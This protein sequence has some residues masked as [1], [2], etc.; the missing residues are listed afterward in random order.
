MPCHDPDFDETVVDFSDVE[1]VTIT[2]IDEH[3]KTHTVVLSPAMVEQTQDQMRLWKKHNNI[4]S[5]RTL[6]QSA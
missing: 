5:P 2:Q 1:Y 6:K 4:P 3:G